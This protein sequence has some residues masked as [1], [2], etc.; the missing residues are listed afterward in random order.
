MKIMVVRC[1][2]WEAFCNFIL[3]CVERGMT[4]EAYTDKLEV[5]LTGGY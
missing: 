2:D 4:F 5:K 1:Q 3:A